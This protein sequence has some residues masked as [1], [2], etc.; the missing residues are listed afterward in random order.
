[1]W[2]PTHLQV[3][4]QRARNLNYKGKNETNDAFVVIAL[5]KDKFQT[6]IKEK[7]TSSVE[8]HEECELPIPAHGNT[9]NVNLTVYHRNALGLDEFLGQIQFPLSEFD[10]YERPR[11]RWHRL[12]GKPEKD[13]KKGEKER[14]ELEIKVAFTVKSGSLLDVSKKEK[15][16]SITSLKNL[17][18]S[19]MSLGSKEKANLKSFAKSVSHKIDKIA[20]KPGKKKGR[21][22]SR[23]SQGFPQE[24]MQ[25]RQRAGDAD[26]GV[27]SDSEDDFGFDEEVTV[28][29]RS[30]SPYST[31]SRGSSV[32][33]EVHEDDGLHLNGTNHLSDSRGPPKPARLGG[34]VLE[35]PSIALESPSPTPSPEPILHAQSEESTTPPPLS[36]NPPLTFP[37]L[38]PINLRTHSD[39]PSLQDSAFSDS[40]TTLSLS[41]SVMTKDSNSLVSLESSF[42]EPVSLTKKV[43]HESIDV[44]K[45]PTPELSPSYKKVFTESPPPVV[46]LPNHEPS[47]QRRKVFHDPAAV[48]DTPTPEPSPSYK[49]VFPESP[50]A[51]VDLP[52]YEP[53]TPY[54]KV[55]TE[56]PPTVVDLPNY[57]SSPPRTKISRDPAAVQDTP[58]SKPSPAYK[59]VFTE[60][61]PA[62]VDLPNH[63]P[64]PQRTKVFHD[65]AA[66]Q[67]PPTPEPLSLYKKVFTESPPAVVN[68]PNHE[69]SPQRRKVFLEPSAMQDPPTP[70]PSPQRRKGFHEPV[71]VQDPP[72]PEPSSQRRK[73]F[74]EP[75]VVQDPPNPEPSPQRRKGFHEPVV[76]QDPPNPEPSPQRRKG[77][78]EPVVVQDPPN[79]EPSPQRRKG[80]HE[81]VVVQ[82]PPNPEPSPQRR[83]GFHEPVVVQDPPIPEPS[84]Q[85]RKGFREPAVMKDPP[86]PEPSPLKR[87]VLNESPA[88]AVQD[89]SLHKPSP[90]QKAVFPESVMVEN[91]PSPVQPLKYSRSHSDTT[92]TT[93]PSLASN[94]NDESLVVLSPKSRS[95]SISSSPKVL[96]RSVFTSSPI[97]E[98]NTQKRSALETLAF[99]STKISLLET[100]PST[101]FPATPTYKRSN[102]ELTPSAP[103]TPSSHNGIDV[104]APSTPTTSA[105][106]YSFGSDY[107]TPSTPAT[108]KDSS[109]NPS[110]SPTSR[111][112]RGTPGLAERPSAAVVRSGSLHEKPTTQP[113]IDE[114][115][116]KL[117][118]R[119]AMVGSMENV[120]RSDS[121]SS[122]STSL[123]SSTQDVTRADEHGSRFPEIKALRL[124]KKSREDGDEGD[125]K[126]R[127]GKGAGLKAKLF[128]NSR[129]RIGE[130]DGRVVEGGNDRLPHPPTRQSRL[131]QEIHDKFA[132]KSREDL[133]EMIVNLQ[134]SL[135]KSVRHTRDLEDYIDGLLLRVMETTPQLLQTPLTKNKK[136][137]VFGPH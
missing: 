3:T 82:D 48:Q 136:T 95:L 133:M 108:P 54:K 113:V 39:T 1:M 105:S 28:N 15:N 103:N 8:W 87:K 35:V 30:S 22:G 44:Q 53:S 56:S 34:S 57:E 137:K 92:T 18:G 7:A 65:P 97:K 59:K 112:S 73:G 77:F 19:L 10:V 79:P 130:E 116:K 36:P 32:L 23:D 27:I 11:N 78:H 70:E 115:E 117:Y 99:S 85:R 132:G 52:T 101:Q 26:P 89:P 129:E 51:V 127:R 71:V 104:S 58:I 98:S 96:H 55:F 106:V 66:V 76:V 2:Q 94:K 43:F 42:H 123:S 24:L 135:E 60:S 134:S 84:P 124:E 14:G 100:D 5:G 49:N 12:K 74:H 86:T 122:L 72:N 20:H 128:G 40:A 102:S 64:S 109:S 75:V 90:L 4:V 131:P 69:P 107:A 120:N 125:G 17:G 47:S 62:V 80:F 121:R 38:T 91:P 126:K 41:S 83:K 93:M 67:G 63:E 16:K 45:T 21:K 31:V 88:A 9:A 25:S 110:P 50:P 68:L 81:P 119:N 114:W 46:D 37:N 33:Q 111:T 6:S 29:T 118:G 61:P 13:R